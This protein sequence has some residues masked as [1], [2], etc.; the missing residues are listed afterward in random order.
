MNSEKRQAVLGK[1]KSSVSTQGYHVTVVQ[2]GPD[3]R[4]AYTIGLHEKVGFELV[5]AGGS[6]FTF[7]EVLAV[8]KD[9]ARRITSGEWSES[10]S[11]D[12]GGLGRMSLQEVEL[13][14]G[15]RMLLGA[16]DYYGLKQIKAFQISPDS[17]HWTID[18]PNMKES[19]SPDSQPTWK[20]LE[21]TWDF[22]VS[23]KSKA[24]TNLDALRGHPITELTRWEAGEWE[25]FAGAGPDVDESD[26]RIVPLGT[27]LGHDATL[28]CIVNLEIGFGLWR[29]GAG[30]EWHPW[31]NRKG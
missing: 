14:W 19:W 30:L 7:D 11:L 22:P 3:P 13:S 28:E 16:L 8:V 2:G 12:F 21:A 25:L 9:F 26:L 20:W 1:I 10:S 27:M 31:G 29:E 4:F 23:P 15:H 5:F 17:E 24:I 6:F 18:V